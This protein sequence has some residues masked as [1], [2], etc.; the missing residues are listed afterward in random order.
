MIRRPPRSTQSRSSAASDVYKRQ[1]YTSGSTGRPKGAM[2][3][4][5]NVV[6]LLFNSKMQFAFGQDDCWT[7]FHSYCF[8]FSVW[9]MYGALL[10]GGR[11][12][13]IPK[14]VAQ[15]TDRFLDVLKKEK[16]TV[17]NQTP[18]AFYNLVDADSKR[19]NQSLSLRYVIFG[20]EALK[21]IMLWP[22]RIRH[23]ETKLINMYGIT[24]TTVHVTYLELSNEDIE[25]NVC[26]IGRPIP[27]TKT[28]ILDG[29]QNPLP[30]GVPGEICVSGDG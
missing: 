17:L 19:V 3:E 11:L 7:L 5:R 1:I 2:I 30:I 24:E 25:S 4:H 23:P 6:R 18:G 28:Y 20:G 14:D 21:P 13:I 26:N 10:Y 16:V 15:D 29:K 22:F 27:T 9:E 8:D 12:I